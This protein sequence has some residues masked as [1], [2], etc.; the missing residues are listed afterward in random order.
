MAWLQPSL[1]LSP[2]VRPAS[3]PEPELGGKAEGGHGRVGSPG[4]APPLRPR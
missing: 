2:D 1:V 3:D 4:W